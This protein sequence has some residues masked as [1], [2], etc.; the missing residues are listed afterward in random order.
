MFPAILRVESGR[1]MEILLNITWMVCSLAL[2]GFWTRY[3]A[4]KSGS[5][6]TQALALSMVVLLLLPV[7]SLSDDRVAMQGLAE[8]DGNVRRALHPGDSH[9]S[10]TSDASALPAPVFSNLFFRQYSQDL[11]HLDREPAHSSVIARS[12]DSR[13]PPRA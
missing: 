6:C 8:S 11:L 1:M 7:I 2:V 4:S 10:P 13:P 5:R 12:L 3:A 9:L